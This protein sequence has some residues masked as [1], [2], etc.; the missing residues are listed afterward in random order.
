MSVGLVI[1]AC[2]GAVVL[3]RAIIGVTFAIFILV[4]VSRGVIVVAIFVITFLTVAF[5][6]ALH[7][8]TLFFICLLAHLLYQSDGLP[9][10]QGH[11]SGHSIWVSRADKTCHCVYCALTFVYGDYSIY[12]DYLLVC[13][14]RYSK[15]REGGQRCGPGLGQTQPPI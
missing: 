15:V 3:V 5:L 8:T 9:L 14:V 1:K 13:R 4:G 2:I 10:D 6:I 12:R 7:C 11:E